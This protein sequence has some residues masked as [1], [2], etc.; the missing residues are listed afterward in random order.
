MTMRRREFLFATTGAAV[1]A[2]K[3][4]VVRPNILLILADDLAAWMLGCYGNREIKTPHIDQLARSG[5]RFA[6]SFVT[7]P[8][9]SAS[10]ATLFTGRVPRQHGIHDFLTEEASRESATR[11]TGPTPVL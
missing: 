2:D 11:A 5:L 7:T 9:C 6:N 4:P 10:R 8:I 1:A 3:K